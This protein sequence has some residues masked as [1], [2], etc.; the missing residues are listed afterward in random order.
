MKTTDYEIVFNV[1]NNG[2]EFVDSSDS[3]KKIIIPYGTI[4]L[5]NFFSN[6][7]TYLP[8][9]LKYLFTY[10]SIGSSISTISSLFNFFNDGKDTYLGVHVFVKDNNYF[11]PALNK[12]DNT[13]QL[14]SCNNFENDVNVGGKKLNLYKT[15]K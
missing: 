1:N 8:T 9:I 6:S 4:I 2:I 7:D 3:E 5:E 15:C 13:V 10:S 11:L 14:G 12:N